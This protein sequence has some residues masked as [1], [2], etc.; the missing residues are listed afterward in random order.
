MRPS[1]VPAIGL[2]ALLALG[3]PRAQA[4]APD[5]A[6]AARSTAEAPA[7]RPDSVAWSARTDT[8]ARSAR[9]ADDPGARRYLNTC[10]GCHLL[11]GAKLNGPALAHV[12]AWPLDQLRTAIK[13]ME[14]NVGPLADADIDRLSEF[15]RAPDARA[16][17]AAQQEII[18]AQFASQLAPPDR[19]AGQRLFQGGQPLDHGGMACVACHSVA[20][21]GGRLGPDLSDAATRLGKLP[22]QSGIAAAAYKV[23]GP[24]YRNHPITPQEAAHITEYLAQLPPPAGARRRPGILALGTSGAALAFAGLA[25]YYRRGR[26]GRGV[27]ARRGGM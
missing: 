2:A 13:R 9:P 17:L 1:R 6:A 26:P 3:A 16:R 24:H 20:G 25:F 7:A 12:A 27:D 11:E 4:T 18:R 10:A 5:S 15:L 14:K 19:N 21:S 23:M 22:L 8:T